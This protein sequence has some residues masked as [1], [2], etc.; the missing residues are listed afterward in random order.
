MK[1]LLPALFCLMLS[2]NAYSTSNLE[3]LLKEL[4]RTIEN[5]DMF[6]VS[7][8]KL[9]V[10]IKSLIRQSTSDDQLYNLYASLY[11]EY[12]NYNLDSAM[13]AYYDFLVA[14]EN[15]LR[16]GGSFNEVP[17]SCTNNPASLA[18]WPPQKGKVIALSKRVGTRQVVHL[19]NFTNAVH[20]NWCDAEGTQAEPK[21]IKSMPINLTT[22]QPVRKVWAATPDS[23]GSLY[24]ELSFSQ[25]AGVVSFE[26][27]ALKYW[28]MI[29]LDY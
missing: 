3:Q 18:Q 8:E 12:V 5:K 7:K 16:D 27:P 26:V 1:K 24:Q 14:Y 6:G 21:L 19:L 22:S 2:L 20:L 17:L 9:I 11:N 23:E 28:T 15:L 13:I 4:D 25:K 10:N 29:V